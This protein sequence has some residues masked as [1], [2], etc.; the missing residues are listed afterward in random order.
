MSRSQSKNDDFGLIRFLDYCFNNVTLGLVSEDLKIFLESYVPKPSK[1]KKCILGVG[2]P[3]IGA[4]ISEELGISCSH[5]GVVPEVLRG[6]YSSF[7]LS[8]LLYVN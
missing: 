6:M 5:I 4:S 7:K 8:T 1:K 2:D 3:K